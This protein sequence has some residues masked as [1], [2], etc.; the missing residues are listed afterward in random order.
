VSDLVVA[1]SISEIPDGFMN[2]SVLVEER[3]CNCNDNGFVG[4]GLMLCTYFAV[5]SSVQQIG[6]V[7]KAQSCYVHSNITLKQ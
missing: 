2:N 7:T 3:I 4:D 6:N 1:Q 5:L